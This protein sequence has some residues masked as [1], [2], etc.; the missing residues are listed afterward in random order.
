M[1]RLQNRE[2]GEHYMTKLEVQEKDGKIYA[3]LKDKWLVA[4]PEEKVRQH[5]IAVLVNEYGYNLDQMAQELKVNNSSRGQGKA[6]ADIVIWK[7]KAD[8]DANKS[9]FIVVECKAEN[10]KVLVEDYYQ[11]FNYASWAHAEFFVTTNEKETKFFKVDP[12]FLP[13]KPEEVVTIPTAKDVADAKKIEQI[14]NQTKTFTR[15]EFTKTLQAC[16]NIIRNNDKLSPEAAFDEI[17]KLLFMKIRYERQQKG[18]KVFTRKQYEAESKNYEENLRPGLKGTALYAQSYMQRLFSTTKEELKDDHLFEE[19]DEIKIR[20]NSFVQIL[21]KLQNFNLSDTQDD[22]KGIAFEQFLGTTFRGELGQ[23]F[24]PRTIVDF[25][26]EILD[27]QEGEVICDPTC[28]SGGFLIKA[29]EYV[30]DKIESDVR[31]QKEVLRA[32]LEG[33]NFDTKSENEQIEITQSIDD[34]QNALNTELD[35]SI[36]GSRMYKLSRNCIYGT[37]ANPRMARTSKMNMIMHGDGHGGVHHH[38]GLLNVNGIFEERFDV[39]LTNPP[40]GQNVDRNQLISEADKFT[41][42][43]MKKKYKRKYGTAYDNALKQVDDN[44]GKSLLY[45]YDLGNTSTLTEVLFMERCLR[46]LKKGGRM[47]MVL[48]EGVLNNKNLQ[49]VRE[50]FEGKAKLILICSIPQDVFI[51]AGATVKPSLVFMKKFTDEEI[52]EYEKCKKEAL[53]EVTAKHQSEIA[54]QNTII[55]YC[56]TLAESLKSA[57]KEARAKLKFANKKKCDITPI[58][59]EIE[60]IQNEQKQNKTNKKDAE[61]ALKTLQKLIEDEFK[62][63][64]KEKFDYDVPIAK[65]DD[66]GITTTG[67]VSENNQLPTLVSEYREYCNRVSMWDVK[68]SNMSY[69][70]ENNKYVRT[71]EN[72]EVVLNG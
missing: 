35:T 55:A 7:S 30:R 71:S 59:R 67:A 44:I 6:R 18:T 68:I 22:V 63:L 51:A 47:G 38:D 62:P 9:A 21:E 12:T 13:Q 20:E 29:F 53:L 66:A 5:Y 70:S 27:P 46:L 25:M 57:L 14:K 24:T 15:E 37:D 31:K 19:S 39:I 40:F 69:R 65:I 10:V 4:K 52:V 58:E 17:S 60:Q 33:N 49:S 45:L 8:K 2:I 72:E 61:I 42:E 48:P 64:T 36:E 26:T 54:A 11:G 32:E 50:Y 23:F 41:D 34:M 16:H 3:P 43:D 1:A 56:E 28:G